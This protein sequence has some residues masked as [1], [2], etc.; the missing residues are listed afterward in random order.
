MIRSIR[1][2]LG[3]ATLAIVLLGLTPLGAAAG[4]HEAGEANPCAAKAANPCAAKAG[5]AMNPCAAK[6]A[7]PAKPANPCAA[8]AANPCAAK[9]HGEAEAGKAAAGRAPS[10]SY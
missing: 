5:D 4:D 7:V 8:K 1:L 10:K 3:A 9:S 2:L 6:A